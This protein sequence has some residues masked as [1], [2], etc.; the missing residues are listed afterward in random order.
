MYDCTMIMIKRVYITT[1]ILKIINY[2]WKININNN[3]DY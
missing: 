1:N 2:K 3:N